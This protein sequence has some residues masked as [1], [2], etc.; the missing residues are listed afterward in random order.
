[1]VWACGQHGGQTHDAYGATLKE[2]GLL[3]DLVV[4]GT[5]PLKLACR[6]DIIVVQFLFDII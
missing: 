5:L 2:R 3:E 4:D 1:M 6:T